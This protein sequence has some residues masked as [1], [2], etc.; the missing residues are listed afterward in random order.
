MARSNQAS[1]IPEED[2]AV[3]ILIDNM[4]YDSAF[5]TE[6]CDTQNIHTNIYN[7]CCNP[8]VATG[9]MQLEEANVYVKGAGY[10]KSAF[11]CGSHRT[12]ETAASCSE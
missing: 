9:P 6:V 12:G 1:P 10:S 4:D 3:S 5:T 2:R 7:V 8:D 11:L